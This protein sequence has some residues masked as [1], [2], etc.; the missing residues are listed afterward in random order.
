MTHPNKFIGT[1][2]NNP[3]ERVYMGAHM[4]EMKGQGR[5]GKISFMNVQKSHPESQL[6][7]FDTSSSTQSCPHLT[8]Q[9]EFTRTTW[10]ILP[11]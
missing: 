5:V 7:I 6:S 9:N 3:P 4:T 10:P 8:H 2:S 11:E 1:P